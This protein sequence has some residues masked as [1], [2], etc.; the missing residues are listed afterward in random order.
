MIARLCALVVALAVA[1]LAAQS[2]EAPHLANGH[3]DFQ[4]VWANNTVTPFARPKT[5]AG[6]EFLTDDEIRVLEQRAA[7]MFNGDGDTAP[8]DAMFE[9]LIG[10]TGTFKTRSA[11]GDYNQVWASE[12]LV[13]EHRT[14]QLIEPASGTLPPLTSEGARRHA[15]FM[16]ARRLH[17]ADGPEDRLPIE[18]CISAG[19][20]KLGFVQTRNNSYYQIVQTG[21]TTLLYTEM[22]RD[23]RLIHMD[24]R[25]HPPASIRSWAGDSRGRWEGDA[26]VI[27][28]TNYHPQAL[29]VPF[30]GLLFSAED[31]HVVERLTQLDAQTLQYRVTVEDPAL[32]TQPWSAVT[33][34]RRSTNRIFEYA[35]H[36][37][38]HAMEGLLRGG[39]AEEAAAKKPD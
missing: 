32:W 31:F 6:R 14:S 10:S 5:L 11:T 13:F 39:R 9:A 2:W 26:L 21:D 30:V 20:I 22:M 8:G 27:D 1:P 23:A 4:G 35:C 25:S 3:P 37:G 12:R 29:F 33:T 19:P 36:E 15:A 18:R 24:G 34:W 38:N 17:P 28:T 16:E 7:V